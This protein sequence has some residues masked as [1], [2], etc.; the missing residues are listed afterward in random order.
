MRRGPKL[1]LGTIEFNKY[2]RGSKGIFIQSLAIAYTHAVVKVY[3]MIPCY[4]IPLV[5]SISEYIMHYPHSFRRDV[6]LD[7][8]NVM[9]MGDALAR[10]VAA[11]NA[12]T[13][14]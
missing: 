14:H 1:L 3:I 10:R 11:V 12:P 7:V 6:P 5:P 9:A 4:P 2:C 13:P 8:K